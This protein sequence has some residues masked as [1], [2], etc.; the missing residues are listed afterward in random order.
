MDVGVGEG[1]VKAIAE[2]D[3]RNAGK[4]AGSR[5]GLNSATPSEASFC[6]L[7]RPKRPVV[8]RSFTILIRSNPGRQ[9]IALLGENRGSETRA[10]VSP[11]VSF[12]SPI[13]NR[14][15]YWF[16]AFEAH[17]SCSV[18]V[19]RIGSILFLMLIWFAR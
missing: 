3:L 2:W 1:W 5:L 11:L 4:R 19:L 13:S 7:L 15:C 6:H 10:A 9:K 17:L 12:G 16:L 14:F 18:R 8:D